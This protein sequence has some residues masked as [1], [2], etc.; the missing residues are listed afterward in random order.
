[1]GRK[2]LV[3]IVYAFRFRSCKKKKKRR[4]KSTYFFCVCVF[5]YSLV[6]VGRLNVVFFLCSYFPLCVVHIVCLRSLWSCFSIILFS[7]LIPVYMLYGH[8]AMCWYVWCF[9][10]LIIP[11]CRCRGHIG[12][13]T[14]TPKRQLIRITKQKKL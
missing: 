4:K 3:C 1:M 5:F 9:E 2:I 14:W 8:V 7:M 13:N 10:F 6:L 12:K 11:L